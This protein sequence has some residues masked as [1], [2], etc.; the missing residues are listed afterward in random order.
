MAFGFIATVFGIASC[1]VD[2]AHLAF[3]HT[4]VGFPAF[5][6]LLGSITYYIS[7]LLDEDDFD[8]EQN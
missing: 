2:L 5:I 1:I 8:E 6:V 7:S 3:Q 4:R